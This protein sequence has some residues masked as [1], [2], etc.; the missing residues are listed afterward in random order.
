[1]SSKTA[2]KL[3]GKMMVSDCHCGPTKTVDRQ[4]YCTLCDQ[5]CN[6]K[7]VKIN[8]KGRQADKKRDMEA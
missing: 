1:M 6:G 3:R 7:F 8:E 2:K 5:K 4:Y